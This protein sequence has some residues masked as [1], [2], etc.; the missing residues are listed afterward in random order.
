MFNT[1]MA[2]NALFDIWTVRNKSTLKFDLDTPDEVKLCIKKGN[3]Y[4]YYI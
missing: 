3:S 4:N 2:L 1:A